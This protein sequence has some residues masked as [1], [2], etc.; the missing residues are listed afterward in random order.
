MTN[1]GVLLRLLMGK[2]DVDPRLNRFRDRL[3]LQKGVYLLQEAFD[4]H[5]DYRFSWYL[6]GPYSPALTKVAFEEVA[7]PATQGD[8]THEGFCLSEGAEE[9]WDRLQRLLDARPNNESEERWLELLASLHFYRH[10][11]YFP[12]SEQ[13]HKKD[14]E[15]LYDKLPESKRNSFLR[16]L[17]LEATR[18]L[19]DVGLW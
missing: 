19:Q 12:Q 5:T 16:P 9:R 6:R 17:A 1:R 7:E 8:R 2:L 13:Q 3:R 14:P 18:V 15:W 11:A 4:M 10:K